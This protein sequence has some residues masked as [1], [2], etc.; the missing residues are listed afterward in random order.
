[1]LEL[2]LD[3]RKSFGNKT[4]LTG[5]RPSYVYVDGKKTDKIDGYAYEVVLPEASY[6][7]IVVK[8][9]SDRPL[10]DKVVGSQEVKFDNLE[11]KAYRTMTGGI[12]ISATA[13]SVTFAKNNG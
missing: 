11:A 7:K 12:G 2:I 9:K 13:A 5:V 3:N 6:E 10:V 4:V 1:M 8:V